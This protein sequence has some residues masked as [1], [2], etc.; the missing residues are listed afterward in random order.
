M[1]ELFTT[2]Q[3]HAVLQAQS[4]KLKMRRHSKGL[5]FKRRWKIG[6]NSRLLFHVPHSDNKSSSIYEVKLREIHLVKRLAVGPLSEVYAAI[7]RDIKVGVKLLMPKEGMIEDMELAVRNFRREI[8]LMGRLKHPNIVHLV[9]ASLTM[10]CY[11]LVMEYMSNGSL[12]DYLRDESNFFP[13]QMIITSAFDIA[14]GMKYIHQSGVLQ[15]DLKS[16]N[17]LLSENLVV[18]V[19]DFGL[20]RLADKSYGVYTFVG[21][22]FWVAPE[23]IR[24]EPYNEKAD[25]YSYGVVLWELVERKDP[26]E[27]LN[28]FQV[29]F[30][31][32]NEGLRPEKL[33][34]TC[35]LGLSELMLSCW[36]ADPSKRPSFPEIYDTIQKLF[37]PTTMMKDLNTH[38]LTAQHS[39]SEEELTAFTTSHKTKAKEIP[40]AFTSRLWHH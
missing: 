23:I 39:M 24:H 19:S 20:S 11:V 2:K 26:Y 38:V 31:V 32:A 33:T 3:E 10:S 14:S 5:G 29:P 13:S 21:T 40:I 4:R 27:G 6:A 15:R 8:W 18:K 25:I 36:D 7:W 34:N 37:A 17:L 1:V 9:G 35:P 12:Y 16:K 22:P 30:L 28:A